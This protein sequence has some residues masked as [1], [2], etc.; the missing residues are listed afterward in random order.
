MDFI[1]TVRPLSEDPHL[2]RIEIDL[3]KDD[4]ACNPLAHQEGSIPVGQT[5]G[6]LVAYR[7][8]QSQFRPT[9]ITR[10][11]MLSLD[12]LS[13]DMAEIAHNMREYGHEYE[14]TEEAYEEY[15][16]G[17]AGGFLIIDRLTIATFARGQG[18]GYRLIE[19]L[20]RQHAGMGM[21]VALQAAAYQ[22]ETRGPRFKQMSRRLARY[23]LRNRSLN[24]SEYGHE[25][26][27]LMGFWGSD[28]NY[29]EPSFREEFED[30]LDIAW[31]SA[32]AS[33][34]RLEP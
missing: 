23:Y 26:G 29:E 24:L 32:T 30:R 9:D 27:F 12:D 1:C 17:F 21:F 3:I 4:E 16:W 15:E 8:F 22:I 18:L 6:R 5:I 2:Q 31:R 13:T 33:Q 19:E 20:K 34:K 25:T 28:E 11:Q 14:E 10:E 7:M